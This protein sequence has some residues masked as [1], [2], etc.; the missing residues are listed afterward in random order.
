[1]SR[2][3]KRGLVRGFI[4]INFPSLARLSAVDW[5]SW[6]SERH[7]R[8]SEGFLCGKVFVSI[9]LVSTPVW[10]SSS[11]VQLSESTSARSRS[12]ELLH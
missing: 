3:H 8:F 10:I 11:R 9:T 4:S 12:E 1:M 6:K 2:L 5:P 7:E